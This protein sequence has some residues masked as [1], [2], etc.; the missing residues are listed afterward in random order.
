MHRTKYRE[1]I[2]SSQGKDKDEILCTI[3]GG[4]LEIDAES[5]EYHC[6]VCEDQEK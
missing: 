1:Q 2:V 6:P 3:C 4:D 5:G